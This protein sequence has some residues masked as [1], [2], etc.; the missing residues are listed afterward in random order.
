MIT[1]GCDTFTGVSSLHVD[2]GALHLLALRC[3][4]WSAGLA[5]VAAP[6]TAGSV[7]AT[8]VAVA[9]TDEWLRAASED[10]AGRMMQFAAHLDDAV[11]SQWA[12]ESHSVT[13]LGAVAAHP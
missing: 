9:A 7:S 6:P 12:T 13:V 3:R 2:T 5:G 11:R 1:R 8:A 10:F 4:N